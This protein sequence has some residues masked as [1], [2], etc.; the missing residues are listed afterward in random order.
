MRD[1]NPIL[2]SKLY[3]LF[4]IFISYTPLYTHS[5]NK[6]GVV[7]NNARSYKRHYQDVKT[8]Y[9][10]L[11]EDIIFIVETRIAL[12]DMTSHY[13]I[14]NIVA[15]HLDQDCATKPYHGLIVYTHNNI[16][17]PSVT[18]FTGQN[19]DVISLV[20]NKGKKTFTIIAVYNSP[21]I[22]QAQ[23]HAAMDDILRGKN[24]GHYCY[25]RRL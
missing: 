6:L 11:T 21:H 10:I 14:P 19:I 1:H 15:H 12:N 13:Y 2:I 24:S 9:N 23:L 18:M 20:V 5:N 4:N 25:F 3:I 8:N 17:V 16:T 7:Y 22:K